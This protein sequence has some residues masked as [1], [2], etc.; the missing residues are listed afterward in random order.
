[1][2]ACCVAGCGSSKGV[3]PTDAGS[4]SDASLLD[5]GAAQDIADPAPPAPAALPV[6]TPCPDGWRPIA[7]GAV[8]VCEP[9]PESGARDDCAAGEA[10]FPGTAG[11]ARVGAA[12]PASGWPEGLP[13]TGAVRYVRAGATPGGDG[14][15]AAPFDS[16]AMATSG[17]AP[18]TIVALAAGTYLEAPVLRSAVLWGACA[19]AT[20]VRFDAPTST[21]QGVVSAAGTGNVVRNLTVTGG[22]SGI[23]TGAPDT[24]VSV[25]GVVVQSVTSAG[26]NAGTRSHLTLR[27]VVIRDVRG[28]A[29]TGQ[30]GYGI[31]VL[32]T[33]GLTAEHLLVE[34][35]HNIAVLADGV[36][37]AVSLHDAAI[38]RTLANAV[39]GVAGRA[40]LARNGAD[41]NLARVVIE[42][43]L[44]IGVFSTGAGSHV[45]LEDS[46]VRRIGARASDGAGG[47]GVVVS[48]GAS[49]DVA[50]V[51]IRDAAETDLVAAGPASSL[52]SADVVLEGSTSWPA[53]GASLSP[54]SAAE[55][56]RTYAHDT[57]HYG[58]GSFETDAT[59]TGS[60]TLRDLVV[61]GV[62][63]RPG[64]TE[65]AFGLVLGAH[66]NVVVERADVQRVDGV[67]ISLQDGSH[68]DAADLHL[69]DMGVDPRGFGVG[70]NLSGSTATVRRM[71]IERAQFSGVGISVASTLDASDVS[72]TSTVPDATG[73][74]GRGLDVGDGSTCTVARARIDDNTEAGIIALGD[75]ARIIL[76]DTVVTRTRERPCVTTVCAG[77]GAGFGVVAVRGGSIDM[78]RFAVTDNAF[79]G[80]QVAVGG[81]MDLHHGE[82]RGQPIGA[83]VQESSFDL[84]RLMDDV[85][86]SDNAVSLDSRILPVPDRASP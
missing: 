43:G 17:A 60:T 38:V 27:D 82:V 4:P 33:G 2:T 11:C 56:T 51:W 69:H 66:S 40:V 16:I 76:T 45:R 28:D 13:S 44:D 65:S 48:A 62:T 75:G 26:V 71:S 64:T 83:N 72:I 68:L 9:W 39:T 57:T 37:T 70:L 32:P 23:V 81:G 35:A 53:W 58:V 84:A 5:G 12:C 24:E 3:A 31:G 20:V 25:E 1:M 74:F 22:R 47:H 80:I 41:V 30:Y 49:I 55:L 85:R 19:A 78:T 21:G 52:T 8:T 46:V 36:G 10:H 79:C 29:T 61:D 73:A 7:A 42:D 34:R 77:L 67:A 59:V 14:S 18:G 50:R 6:M 63:A 15:M 86:F 54:Q